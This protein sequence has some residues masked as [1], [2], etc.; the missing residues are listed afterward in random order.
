MC[1][2]PAAL[3]ALLLLPWGCIQADQETTLYPDGSGKVLIEIGIKKS[4][5][6][7]AEEMA[8]QSGFQVQGG[9]SPEDLFKEF[10]SPAEVLKNTEGVV[11]WKAGARREDAD[12]VRS[13]YTAYFDDINQLRIYSAKAGPDGERKLS[14]SWRLTRTKTGQQAL[15]LTSDV[16]GEFE[17][18]SGSRERGPGSE[19]LAKAM[20]EMMKPMFDGFKVALRVTVPGNIQESTG[21]METSGRRASFTLEGNA[22][23]AASVNPN[24]PEARRL[25]KVGDARDSKVIWEGSSLAPS[26]LDAWRKELDAAKQEWARKTGRP[27][28]TPTAPAAR[29]PELSDDEVEAGFIKA[30]IKV[31]RTHLD[32]GRKDKAR[33]IL[34]RVLKDFPKHVLVKDAR[35]LLESIR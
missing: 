11:G 30:K 15:Y 24:G 33:E 29:E 34:E 25:G 35:A 17:K 13:S 12:W 16:R 6:K 22:L 20:V 2:R 3:A 28:G 1:S 8:K 23:I 32:A 26:E 10:E 19:E 4:I 31:A 18:M 5:M 7:V 21:F 9:G 14:V 27:A